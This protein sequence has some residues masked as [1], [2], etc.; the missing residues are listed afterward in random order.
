[1]VWSN[2]PK[3]TVNQQRYRPSG[4]ITLMLTILMHL[5]CISVSVIIIGVETFENLNQIPILKSNLKLTLA[6]NGQDIRSLYSMIYMNNQ[7]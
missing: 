6:N 3:V 5:V 2:G 7:N 4:V 1:M